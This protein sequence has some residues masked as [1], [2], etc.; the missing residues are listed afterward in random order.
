M[1]VNL[2]TVVIFSG[3]ELAVHGPDR[4][5]LIGA[6]TERMAS[7]GGSPP[8]DVDAFADPG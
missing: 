2:A 1:L 3:P 6:C 7:V 8:P 5:A 4:L